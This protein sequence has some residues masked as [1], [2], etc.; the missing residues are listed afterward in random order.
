MGRGGA[1]QVDE[2]AGICPLFQAGQAWGQQRGDAEYL[3][4]A[5]DGEEVGWVAESERG[6]DRC[7]RRGELRGAAGQEC[8]CQEAVATQYP[9][10]FDFVCIILISTPLI[11]GARAGVGKVVLM[12]I[13]C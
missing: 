12:G 11:L 6:R 10:T 1:S 4:D 5:Q 3:P 7:R 9:I 2:D 13:I 8:G